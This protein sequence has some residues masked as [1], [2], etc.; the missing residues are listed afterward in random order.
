MD[1][2]EEIW[3][4]ISLIFQGMVGDRGSTGAAGKNGQKVVI[5]K[6]PKI[7]LYMHMQK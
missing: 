5:S 7:K 6:H 3:T 2:F 4:N 1:Y